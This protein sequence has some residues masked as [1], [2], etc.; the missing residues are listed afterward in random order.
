META[1]RVRAAFLRLVNLRMLT[2][3]RIA[4]AADVNPST[5]YR[6]LTPAGKNRMVI[7]RALVGAAVQLAEESFGEV[8]RALTEALTIQRS[9]WTPT[10]NDAAMAA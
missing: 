10:P 2:V 9:P 5:A 7:D 3:K 1:N 8:R 4:A 6:W